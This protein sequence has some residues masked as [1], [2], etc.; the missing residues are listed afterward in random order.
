MTDHH[1]NKKGF[2]IVEA[3][4]AMAI[5]AFVIVTILGGFSQQQVATR[6][7]ASKNTAILLAEMRLEELLKFPSSQL[8]P[9]N[10]TQVNTDFIISRGNTFEYSN[11]DMNDV[12]QFRRTTRI[13]ND[14]LELATIQVMVEYGLDRHG[15]YPFRVVLS[16][17]RG[18]KR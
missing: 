18:L 9:I 3:L 10:T 16:T 2:T 5:L 7:T 15:T 1:E 11:D 6:K 14:T 13:Q 12:D 17:R 4:V 8:A